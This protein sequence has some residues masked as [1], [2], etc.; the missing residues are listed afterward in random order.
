[1]DGA[2]CAQYVPP[3]ASADA[4]RAAVEFVN[5]GANNVSTSLALSPRGSPVQHRDSSL[6]PN[7]F[8]KE[9]VVSLL[10]AKSTGQTV[11]WCIAM[12]TDMHVGMEVLLNE[13]IDHA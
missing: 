5:G 13:G 7:A 2:C 1:M 4:R 9:I 3:Q 6:P 8:Q 12:R 10:M 11:A